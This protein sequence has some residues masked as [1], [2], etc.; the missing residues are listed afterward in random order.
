M[1]TY[2]V[3]AD[4]SA[5]GKENATSDAAA[6][7]SMSLSE[8]N[9]NNTYS[10]GDIIVVSDA[11]G[12]YYGQLVPPSAGSSGSQITYKFKGDV[13]LHASTVVTGWSDEGGNVWSATVNEDPGRLW[14]DD[15]EGDEK[16]GTGSFADEYDWYWDGVDTLYLYATADPDGA[17]TAIEYPNNSEAINSRKSYLTYAL[18]DSSSSYTIRYP[19]QYCIQIV[20]DASAPLESVIVEDAIVRDNAY[21]AE[22]WHL[23]HVGSVNNFEM[24]RV[25]AINADRNALDINL[26]DGDKNDT[27]ASGYLIE[28]CY[29]Q[30]ATHAGINV[31]AQNNR[32][33]YSDVTV[34]YNWVEGTSGDQIYIAN[35][36]SN[37]SSLHDVKV[38]DNICIDGGKWGINFDQS[39]DGEYFEDVICVNN[40]CYGN[41]TLDTGGGINADCVGAIIKNNICAENNVA[42]GVDGEIW[43]NDNGGVANVV[44]Y[45]CVYHSSHTD[46]YREDG[47]DY[48]H[49]EYVSFGQQANG[50]NSDPSFTN[51]GSDDY[52]LAS[53]SPCIDAGTDLGADYD[54]CLDPASSWPDSVST[55]DQDDHG[56]GWE[57]GAYVYEDTEPPEPPTPVTDG[58]ARVIGHVIGGRKL[59]AGRIVTAVYNDT[60][61]QIDALSL[62][63]VSGTYSGYPKVTL[64]DADAEA[65]TKGMIVVAESNIADEDTG[66]AIV[67]GIVEGFTGLTTGAVQYVSTTSGEITETAPSGSGDIVRV[68]GYA[69]S[70]TDLFFW[71]DGS[72][73]E[74]A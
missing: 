64:T 13:E 71:P 55:L 23:I 61:S 72:W 65:T 69:I 35:E 34:R 25:H 30:N 15:N 17:Y 14:I 50:V 10:A 39:G 49:A 12:T 43:V 24:R 27:A 36:S 19:K 45:N 42:D 26:Y 58:L 21:G 60:G 38:Y 46:L 1:A 59:D 51:A 16:A 74:I 67:L 62:C 66:T 47:T 56:D 9:W 8:H 3:R 41:G 28:E 68:A 6:A 5:S 70:T 37:T 20:T 32:R 73:E 57:I 52:T 29:V 11:G 31:H 40:T 4:G 33:P 63:Y 44:D 22:S 48:T 18:Y 54:D 2:Y 53:D 7:T